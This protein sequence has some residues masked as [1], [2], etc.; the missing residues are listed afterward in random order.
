MKDIDRSK[1]YDSKKRLP[2]TEVPEVSESHKALLVLEAR[3]EK[4]TGE[5]RL[6]IQEQIEGITDRLKKE[7]KLPPT[8]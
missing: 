5:D 3:L 4:A 8:A 7:G 2:G 6:R 1:V